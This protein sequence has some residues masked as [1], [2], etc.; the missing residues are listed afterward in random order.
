MHSH[1]LNWLCL[2]GIAFAVTAS[3]VGCDGGPKLVPVEGRVTLDGKPFESVKVLFYLPGQGPETNYTAV[4]DA[5]GRFSLTSL[6]GERVGVAP[7][8][9]AVNLTTM[10]WAVDALETDP[11]PRELVP[12]SKRNHQ[13]EVLAEGMQDANFEL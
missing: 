7:G 12:R 9:Y 2:L 1:K 10:H 6:D 11:Q 3:V 13:F 5:E 4:T 8:T